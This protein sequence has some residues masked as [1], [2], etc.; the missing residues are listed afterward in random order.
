MKPLTED[1]IDDLVEQA[2]KEG[3]QGWLSRFVRLI[4]QAHGVVS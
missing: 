1:Q 4:E 3:I 2:L